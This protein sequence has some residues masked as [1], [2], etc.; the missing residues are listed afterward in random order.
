MKIVRAKEIGAAAVEA[1]LQKKAFDEV[2]L[3]PK[4]R[5]ANRKLFGED[6]TAAELVRRIVTDVREKGDRAVIEY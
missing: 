5:E 1:L 6:L 2:E 3:N 4:I